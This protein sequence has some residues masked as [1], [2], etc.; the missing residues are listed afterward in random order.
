[1]ST[2]AAAT[3]TPTKRLITTMVPD[4]PT[5]EAARRAGLGVRGE[6]PA[7]HDSGPDEE[8][9]GHPDRVSGHGIVAVERLL[10][11]RPLP[12]AAQVA[13]DRADSDRGDEEDELLAQ[14]VEPAVLEVDR[15]H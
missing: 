11:G 6:V 8:Q 5:L 1:M 2:N 4:E 13:Q 12:L 3:S 7:H 15:R 14:G 9:R 10:A